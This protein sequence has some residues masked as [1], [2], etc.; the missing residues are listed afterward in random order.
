MNAASPLRVLGGASSIN[1]RKVLWLSDELRLPIVHEPWGSGIR[2]E[3][4]PEPPIE[5]P[6]LP[7]VRAYYERLAQRPGFVAHVRH[8]TP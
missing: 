7:A 3:L 2:S 6:D 4:T 8:G 1:V 5:R